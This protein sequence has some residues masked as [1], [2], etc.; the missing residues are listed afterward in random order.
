MIAKKFKVFVFD[1]D[2]LF[3]ESITE[4][5]NA[6]PNM[7]CVGYAK[8]PLKTKELMQKHQPDLVLMDFNMKRQGDGVEGLK[9]IKSAFSQIKVLMLTIFENYSHYRE[10]KFYNMDGYWL[11]TEEIDRT[12]AKCNDVLNGETPISRKMWEAD[13]E[14]QKQNEIPKTK[15]PLTLREN[16]VLRMI[17]DSTVVTATIMA[18]K[19]KM[20]VN[21][22]N[23]HLKN[24]YRALD[25]GGLVEAVNLARINRWYD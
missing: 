7:E 20:P 4:A 24:I 1:D 18:D 15:N 25:V 6:T 9:V 17:Y 2:N 10:C 13:I 5:I 8:N 21:T 16:E 23:V 19:L 22:Y 11:K 3:L 12:I 14:A